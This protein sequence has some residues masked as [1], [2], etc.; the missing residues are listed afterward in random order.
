ME[1]QSETTYKVA[2][3]VLKANDDGSIR[4]RLITN[5]VDRDSEVL[6]PAG[7]QLQNWKKN[8]V[9]L[10]AHNR[11]AWGG[12]LRPPIGKIIPRSI[13]QTEEFLDV[14]V[15][16][17]E[18]NDPFAQMIAAK[19]RDGFL[20]ATSVGFIP[21]TISKDTVR[22]GQKG[23]THEKFE[24][25]EGSSVPIPAN[26]AALQQN[27]WGEFVDSCKKYGFGDINIKTWMKMAGW[28]DEDIKDGLPAKNLKVNI[29]YETN[30]TTASRNYELTDVSEG[31]EKEKPKLDDSE[32]E[33]EADK[34]EDDVSISLFDKELVVVWNALI[35]EDI[36]FNDRLSAINYAMLELLDAPEKDNT[37]KLIIDELNS[38]NIHSE[39]DASANI[40]TQLEEIGNTLKS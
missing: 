6:L 34:N 36:P 30:T 15:L 23:V 25:L 12:N 37:Y 21:I 7:A 29:P 39:P 17:D 5:G 19:H 16:F 24:V 9:W 18:E 8:G 27:E 31:E 32:A 10:W 35:Q 28:S 11:E 38:I 22:P 40:L 13:D 3:S 33:V 1:I 14:S 2:G 20:K 26:P 4:F